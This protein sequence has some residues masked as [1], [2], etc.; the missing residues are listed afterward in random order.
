MITYK[1]SCRH[2][3]LHMVSHHDTALG[4]WNHN[5]ILD[6]MKSTELLALLLP[7]LNPIRTEAISDSFPNLPLE[8]TRKRHTKV[9]SIT[10]GTEMT[11][12]CTTLRQRITSPNR[13]IIKD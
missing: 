8:S 3:A 2:V 7:Q 4:G 11:G 12:D 9:G 10:L 6:A 1:E 5:K 13:I